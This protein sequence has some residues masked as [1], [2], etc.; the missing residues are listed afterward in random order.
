[1]V[2]Q[3]H[4]ACLLGEHDAHPPRLFGQQVVQQLRL[5]AAL[6]Q[7]RQVEDQAV[8]AVEQVLAEAAALHPFFQCT[9]GSTD[10]AH[11]HR[12]RLAADG[13]Y[14]ALLQHPQ[15]AGL[16]RQRHVADLVEEQG[17]AV[18]L[19]QL[20]AHA[21]LARAGEAAA[22]I[23][24]QFALDQGFRNGRAVQRHEGFVGA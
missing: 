12:Q 7:G 8:E 22:A 1:M 4:L 19:L 10:D 14:L 21:F 9:V 13:H 20:A 5:V 11:V 16:Q 2:I 23:A 18:G 3:Q 15:Q 24:E 17:A 6:T